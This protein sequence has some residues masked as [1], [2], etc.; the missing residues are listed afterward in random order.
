M[1]PSQ[2]RHSQCDLT[3]W[4]EHQH[5]SQYNGA[6]SHGGPPQRRSAGTEREMHERYGYRNGNGRERDEWEDNDRPK[7]RQDGRL[8][9]T[10]SVVSTAVLN[11]Y[12]GYHRRPVN[13]VKFNQN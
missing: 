10:A 6:G 2:Y 1:H 11:H 9:D 5:P 13:R 4:D 8:S 12:A 7:R 3:E